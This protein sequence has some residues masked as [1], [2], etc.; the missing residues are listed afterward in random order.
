[1]KTK[2]NNK[3]PLLTRLI[4]FVSSYVPLFVIIILKQV[5]EHQ[6]YLNFGGFSTQA[7]TTFFEKFLISGVLLA[8]SLAG[9]IGLVFFTKSMTVRLERS[10]DRIEIKKI[11]NKNNESIG[12]VATYLVPFMYQS[13]S[14][15]FEVLSFIILMSVIFVIYVNSTLIVV[16]PMLNLWYSLYDI[17]YVELKS[18][19]EKNGTFIITQHNIRRSDRL[20]VK[21]MGN[22]TF[23][24]R[25]EETD[26]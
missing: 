12:Y 16:N 25:L 24:S 23:F 15:P 7:V 1:M 11:Q 10:G 21:D 26:E 17:E 20:V 5:F 13:F 14:T 19:L 18:G 8:V 3:L 2:R 22:N 9:V 6:Q 4:L